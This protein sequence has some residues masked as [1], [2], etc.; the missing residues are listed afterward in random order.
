[1]A[2]SSYIQKPARLKP[3]P[4]SEIL[5]RV[6]IT[7]LVRIAVMLVLPIAVAAQ[8]GQTARPSS[9]S[10]GAPG[11]TAAAPAQQPTSTPAPATLRGHITRQD[12]GRPIR[13]AQ[14]TLSPVPARSGRTYTASTDENGF[15]ELTGIVPRQYQLDVAKSGFVSAGYGNTTLRGPTPPLEVRPG[16]V[17]QRVD[18]ALARGGSISGRIVDETGEPMAGA[19]VSVSRPVVRDWRSTLQGEGPAVTT[20]GAGRY[21]VFGLRPGRYFISVTPLSALLRSQPHPGY[22]PVFYPGTDVATA[23]GL[24]S[25]AT[26]EDV[27]GIDFA[28]GPTRGGSISGHVLA[29]GHTLSS[30]VIVT[31]RRQGKPG[32][33]LSAAPSNRSSIQ[34]TD[35]FTFNAVPPGA[36][37]IEAIASSSDGATA[38]RAETPVEITGG[39]ALRDVVVRVMPGIAVRGHVTYES[40]SSVAP[41]APRVL[42]SLQ[43]PDATRLQSEEPA[44]VAADGTFA[45]RAVQTPQFLLRAQEP[46]WMLKRVLLNGVDV[47]D[48]PVDLP[49]RPLDGIEIVLTDRLSHVTGSVSDV[50]GAAMSNVAV[51]AFADDPT[52][53]SRGTRFIGRAQSD[54]QGHFS[55]DGLPSGAYLVTAVPDFESGMDSDRQML[56]EWRTVATPATLRDG[57]TVALSLRVRQ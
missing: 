55:I 44:P 17:K 41:V 2:R 45:W 40:A 21:R 12:D 33:F 36:Y 30:T 42:V 1:M 4:Q 26:S 25:V 23:E 28:I 34:T 16:E 29:T 39:A 11:T 38:L 18:L 3:D 13:G 19:Q 7:A 51:V 50:R 24:V 6:R 8:S 9:P 10:S 14:L 48:Q 54:A 43:S 5:A 20:D 49:T 37:V 22:A 15:Y 56:D 27:A 35:G 32:E 47:T 53:W 46:G 31:L 57:G 52:K